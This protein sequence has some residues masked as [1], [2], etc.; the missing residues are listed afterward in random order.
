MDPDNC[1]EEIRKLLSELKGCS[2]LELAMYISEEL[3]EKIEA[4]DTWISR[5]G[6]LPK[7]WQK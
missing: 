3:I 5:G 1:L 2:E 4:L 6:Y 7:A